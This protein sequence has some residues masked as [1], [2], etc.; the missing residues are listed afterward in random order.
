MMFKKL[1]SLLLAVSVGSVAL[2]ACGSKDTAKS[3]DGKVVITVGNWPDEE[4]N[5][6]LYATR[7]QLKDDFEAQNPDITI[8][9]DGWAYDVST[10]AAKAEG[11]TLPTVY[12]T[13]ATEV[14]KII[15]LEYSADI[16]DAMKKYGYYDS[17]SE[18]MMK[19][20]SRDGRVY[21]LPTSAYSLG[22]VMNLGLFE[23][24]GLLK[25]DGTPV[26]PDTFDD[27][28]E[29]AKVIKEKTGKAGFLFPTT[30]NGGGWN[31]T[32]LAWSFGGDF[33][34]ETD[35]GW[36]ADFT[37]GVTDALKF[38]RDMKWEDNTLPTETL[39]NNS[40]AMKLIATDQA[41]MAFA[42]PGQLDILTSQ[43][44]MSADMIGFAKMPAGPA[45]RVSLMGG[46]Y[47]AF[48][49]ESTPEQIDA[50][51]KWL[52]LKGDLPATELTDE[53]KESI[54]RSQQDKIDAGRI[55]GIKD[56]VL[57]TTANEAEAYK[58]EVIEELRNIP[59]KNVA[60]YNDK[61]GLSYR[62]EEKM[63]AQDL[64]ALLDSCIQEV[65][66]N[67]NADCQALLDKAE[68]DFQNNNLNNEK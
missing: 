61:T 24:A 53:V 48:S 26:I 15:D 50:A 27:V 30:S 13:Y 4:T 20:V 10:F 29:M 44:G 37:S 5:A 1:V 22:I 23:Q 17:L 57:W 65:F 16:T 41:A 14:K 25:E 38:L 68:A 40:D 19:E 49:P 47:I 28:R 45:A 2:S 60:S 36:K 67:E 56:I 21:V 18:D 6:K 43:Y 52:I 35:E 51:F 7:M 3:D 62:T 8:K 32:N 66:T 11:G 39:I 59:E 9:T 33:M 54:R 58:Q 63:C 64:Y 42:H 31:F 34:K 12:S 46:D 55:V